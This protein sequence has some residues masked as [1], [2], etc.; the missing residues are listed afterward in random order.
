MDSGLEIDSPYLIGLQKNSNTISIYSTG[1]TIASGITITS[2]GI[3]APTSPWTYTLYAKMG[4][5]PTNPVDYKSVTFEYSVNTEGPW[6]TG[7][8]IP[9]NQT[10]CTITSVLSFQQMNPS[11]DDFY[12]RFIVSGTTNGAQITRTNGT[13]NNCPSN[14][15][16]VF[17][18][19]GWFGFTAGSNLIENVT[20]Y[21][22][23]ATGVGICP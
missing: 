1:Y 7:A 18:S 5:V 14:T 4:A 2:D 21:V 8:T 13:P 19:G 12:F 3:C 16:S 6:V 20:I 10:G 9:Y 17:C 15:S 11:G 22:D 23:P